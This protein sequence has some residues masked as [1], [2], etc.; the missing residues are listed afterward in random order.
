M[1]YLVLHG[2]T[3]LR[4]PI[5]P[6]HVSMELDEAV[7]SHTPSLETSVV[8]PLIAVSGDNAGNASVWLVDK[9]MTVHRRTVKTSKLTGSDNIRIISGL[10]QGETIAI[11]GVSK[12][13]EGQ[14]IRKL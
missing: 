4:I 10:E 3:G 14:V 7:E 6:P 9:N 11:S 5:V 12:L 1:C 2:Q 8:I 13:Q